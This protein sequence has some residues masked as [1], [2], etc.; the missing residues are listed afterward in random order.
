MFSSCCLLLLLLSGA[1]L[2][3]NW[4][5]MRCQEPHFGVARRKLFAS[6]VNGRHYEYTKG[7]A[8][9]ESSFGAKAVAR[10]LRLRFASLRI[11][12]LPTPRTQCNSHAHSSRAART[13]CLQ[14]CVVPAQLLLCCRCSA[15]QALLARARALLAL[16]FSFIITFAARCKRFVDVTN[17]G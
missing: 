10:K 7:A 1:L 3:R 17:F 8:M 4:L 14:T 11:L 15:A 6:V 12:D 9:L 16:V 2:R 13:R 5:V